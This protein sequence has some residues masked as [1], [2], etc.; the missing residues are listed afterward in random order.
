MLRVVHVRNP[1]QDGW[2]RVYVRR[3]SPLGNPYRLGKDGTREEVIARYHEWLREQ[4]KAGGP[5]RAELERL[6]ALVRQGKRVELA[7]WCKPAACHGDV[8]ADAVNR[9]VAR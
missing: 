3:P 2:V 1:A 9:L 8:I 5:A 4:W 6:A 7:C